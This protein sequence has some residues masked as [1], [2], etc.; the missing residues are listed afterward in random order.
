MSE[1]KQQRTVFQTMVASGPVIIQEK[2]GVWE[3]DFGDNTA[4]DNSQNPYH[5]YSTTTGLYDVSLIVT[6][7]I[8]CSDTISKIITITDD[9]WIWVPNSFTPDLDGKNDKF[10]IAYN[11]I[12]E[13]NVCSC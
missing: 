13:E 11:G 4:L 3:W 7:D 1:I 5:T 10:C 6:D 9:Y 8:G 2:D 12:R